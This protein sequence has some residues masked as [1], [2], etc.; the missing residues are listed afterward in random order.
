[1]NPV[2]KLIRPLNCIM[3][4]VGVFI[5]ALI[6]IGLEI[7]DPNFYGQIILATEVA[8]LFMASG[9]KMNHYFDRDIDKINHPD[10][11]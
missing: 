11:K 8:F 1:M 3:G 10:S 4:A 6:G 7:L 5:G 9:N 2:L